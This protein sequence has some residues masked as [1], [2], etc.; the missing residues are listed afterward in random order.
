[1]APVMGEGSEKTGQWGEERRVKTGVG[2]ERDKKRGRGDW[3][4]DCPLNY[5]LRQPLLSPSP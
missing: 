5:L 2:W 4:E 1:M 3:E